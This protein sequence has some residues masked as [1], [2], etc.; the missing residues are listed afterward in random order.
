[1]ARIAL[2]DG[3]GPDVVRALSLRPELAR[4]VGGLEQ[5]VWGS[6]LDWRL[7]EL[8]RMQVAIINECT[9]CLGWRSPQAVE[10]GVTDELLAGVASYET[11]PDFTETER[12][13]LEY[14]RHFCTDSARITDDLMD[15]LGALL[16]PDE[17]VELTLVIGKYLSMGRFMQVLGLDQSC[18]LQ[19]DRDSGRVVAS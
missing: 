11:F 6:S 1:M 10:A 5:A 4:A 9:V 19:F 13:A 16:G 7:H 2:P 17:I 8:V 12:V 3:D 18:S 14:T 15:R